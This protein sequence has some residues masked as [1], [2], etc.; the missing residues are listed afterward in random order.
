MPE[1]LSCVALVDAGWTDEKDILRSL[2]G[3][4]GSQF[5]QGGRVDARIEREIEGLQGLVRSQ[6][7]L[8]ESAP[9]LLEVAPFRL[10]GEQ[11][12]EK[13]GVAPLL[14]ERLAETFAEGVEHA[15]QLQAR[16]LGLQEC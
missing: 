10:V 1:R 13:L 6:A 12:V 5:A 11:H 8:G 9:E 4:A 16:Q 7:A 14:S 2:H 3:V 15:G